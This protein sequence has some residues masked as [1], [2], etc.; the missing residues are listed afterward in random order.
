[1]ARH[2]NRTIKG[3]E[4]KAKHQERYEKYWIGK[5]MDEPAVI[6]GKPAKGEIVGVEYVGNSV[7][8]MVILVLENGCEY[9]VSGRGFR[10]KK[11]DVK[12][13]NEE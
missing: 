4:L 1:M 3:D 5:I 2:K 9:P 7:Y 11:D 6:N 12:L 8:G 13:K 10:P